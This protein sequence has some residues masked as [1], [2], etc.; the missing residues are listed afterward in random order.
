MASLAT[1]D[2]SG[3]D[4]R[5]RAPSTR[6]SDGCFATQATGYLKQVLQGS[7]AVGCSGSVHCGATCFVDRDGW[8]LDVFQGVGTRNL[9]NSL[10]VR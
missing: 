5:E 10:R 9:P 6:V 1:S 8:I 2:P 7:I 3:G 4:R